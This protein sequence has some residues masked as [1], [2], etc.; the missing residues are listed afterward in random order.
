MYGF[1]EARAFLDQHREVDA[2]WEQ[3]NA[4]QLQPGQIPSKLEH[5]V[6]AARKQ[7]AEY[8]FSSGTYAAPS[9]HLKAVGVNELGLYAS[10][11]HYVQHSLSMWCI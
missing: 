4:D 9:E 6:Q 3:L 10:S 11:F 7:G 5:A 1:V 2:F 8:F